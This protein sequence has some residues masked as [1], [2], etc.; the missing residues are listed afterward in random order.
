MR[1]PRLRSP[2][3]VPADAGAAFDRPHPIAEGSAGRQHLLVTLGV[4][5]ETA[6]GQDF[7]S[8]VD[9]LDR[10]RSLVWIHPDH[11]SAHVLVPP[12]YGYYLMPNRE[13]RATLSCTNPS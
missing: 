5:G 11:D 2:G 12:L 13:G 1:R 7:L 10:G 9:G 8:F 3:D 6:P 4:G